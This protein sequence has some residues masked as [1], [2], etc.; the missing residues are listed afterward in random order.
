MAALFFPGAQ[1]RALA[2]GA[3]RTLRGA[4]G[5]SGTAVHGFSRERTNQIDPAISMRE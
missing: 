1:W 2:A 3:R 5:R 4:G